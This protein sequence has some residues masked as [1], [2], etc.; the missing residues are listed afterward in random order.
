VCFHILSAHSSLHFICI[1]FSLRQAA[2]M[3]MHVC[4]VTVQVQAGRVCSLTMALTVSQ[5]TQLHANDWQF[6]WMGVV[7]VSA[8]V[9]CLVLAPSRLLWC[10]LLQT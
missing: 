8:F 9:M 1:S 5:G 4:L 2:R 6:W 10:S 7:G 3:R